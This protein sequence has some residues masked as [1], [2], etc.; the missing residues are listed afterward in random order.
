MASEESV[1][2]SGGPVRIPVEESLDLPAFRAADA[3]DLVADYV[4]AAAEI[5]L[6]VVRVIHGRGRG[7]LRGLV[8]ASLEAHPLVD[9]FWDDPE[10]RLGATV[11][12]LVH[13]SSS[14]RNPDGI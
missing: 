7:V 10:S 6:P 11:A 13:R 2:D 3:R 1:A 5:G 14:P 12:R 8:Q 9:A 4:D